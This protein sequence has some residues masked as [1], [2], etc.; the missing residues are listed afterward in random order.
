MKRIA[1]LLMACVV[2]AGTLAGAQSLGDY[3]RSVRKDK[4]IPSAAGKHYDND[5]LPK[6]EHL[7]VVG[8]PPVQT[9]ENGQSKTDESVTENTTKIDGSGKSTDP[10]NTAK[11]EKKDEKT[12]QQKA[13]EWKQRLDDQKKQLAAAEK[14][15]DLL[16]R[17]YRLRAAA[18]YA[19]V[20]NR[21]R[22]QASWDKEEREYKS[23][24]A[25]KEKAVADAK[26]KL[27]DMQENARKAGAPASSRE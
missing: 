17:E 5:N 9:A 2:F 20:G 15:L 12:D 3:A 11:D 14:E 22:N 8:P 6:T 26:Q 16:N 21:L 1:Q 27:D 24:I 13:D 10:A 4:S 23:Q 19:D 25:D 7:S 18:M